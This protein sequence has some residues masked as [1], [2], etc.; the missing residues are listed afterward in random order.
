MN[1]LKNKDLRKI[2]FELETNFGGHCMS[3]SSI[4]Y[5][6]EE[7]KTNSSKNNL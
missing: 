3:D 1:E 4:V 6:A 5:L 7:S 2:I